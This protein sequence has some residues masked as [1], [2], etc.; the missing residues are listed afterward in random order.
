MRM[1][2]KCNPSLLEANK[3]QSMR[4]PSLELRNRRK[5]KRRARRKAMHVAGTRRVRGGAFFF[6]HEY[7]T[8]R[9]YH[10]RKLIN[11][12]HLSQPSRTVRNAFLNAEQRGAR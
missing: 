1:Y 8:A 7:G 3:G 10:Y 4:G 9:S 2:L 12:L 6:V 11:P 5:L